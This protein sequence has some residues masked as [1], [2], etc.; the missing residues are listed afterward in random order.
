FGVWVGPRGGYNFYGSLADIL[1]K[2]GKGSKAGASI[3]VAD[4]TYFN[5]LKDMFCEWQSE[6]GVNYWKWDGFAVQA[7]YGA[8]AAADG[9]PGYANRH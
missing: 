5:N 8:F 1:V 6:Y 7:Q 3:D 9:V 4:R 2:S